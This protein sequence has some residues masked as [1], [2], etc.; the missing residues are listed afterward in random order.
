MAVLFSKALEKISKIVIKT[1]RLFGFSHQQDCFI[2]DSG[3]TTGVFAWIGKEATKEER[4]HAIKAAEAF[5]EKNGLPKWTRVGAKLL[6]LT[7]I[8]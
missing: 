2:L 7:K 3:T 1:K 5:L 8:C 4:I 6:L